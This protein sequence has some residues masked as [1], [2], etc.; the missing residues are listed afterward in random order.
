VNAGNPRVRPLL[1][2]IALALL[3][4]VVLPGSLYM[5]NRTEFLTAPAPILRLLLVPAALL[6]ALALVGLRLAR[7]QDFSR[8]CSVIAALILLAWV[9]AYVLVWDYGLLDGSPIDWGTPAWRG[10]VDLGVWLAGLGAAVALHRRLARPLVTAAF[11]VVALQS[12]LLLTDLFLHRDTLAL[13][14]TK[15]VAAEE[16]QPMSRFSGGRNVL[17]IVLDSFQADVFQEIVTGPGGAEVQAALP[18]FTFFEEHLGTF[19][20]TYLAMPVIVSGQVY[21]NHVPRA[22]FIESAYAGKTILSAAHDAGYEVDVAADSWTLD[23]L[24]K[25]RFDNAYLTAQLPLVQEAARLFDLALFRLSPH[26]LKPWIYNEQQWLTQRLVTRSVLFKFA[27]FTHNAF[28]A[29][30]TRD[31]ATDRETPVYKFFHLMTPHTPFVVNAD[32]S[33]SGRV[34]P[35]TRENVTAQSRCSLDFVIA[36]LDRMKQAGIYD[37]SLVVLMGDHGG[38][39][40]P[41]RYRPGTIRQDRMVYELPPDFVGL[42]TPLLAIKPPGASG[43]FRVSAA[44]TSMTDVAATIDALLGLGGDLPGTSLWDDSH[45]QSPER[46]FYAYRWSGR[47]PVSEYI[48][49]IQEHTVSGSA[50]QVESWH[51]GPKFHPPGTNP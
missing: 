34:V 36:L 23:L 38:H 43:A 22:E 25:G 10:W 3:V 26:A 1:V 37:D 21:R 30:I 14:A 41:V 48:E 39:V 40:P 51:V 28:L 13:K 4:F 9:Q 27:Y 31:F 29:S 16:I 6:I 50:Y 44:L 35:R 47:D 20:A 11:A 17:H 49:V 19:P 2:T 7:T 8:Y 12:G 45:G 18:G 5:G 32:C 42:A 15:R 33:P 24:M 46:R